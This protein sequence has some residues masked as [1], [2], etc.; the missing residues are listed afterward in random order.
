M[1]SSRSF[2]EAAASPVDIDEIEKV[3]DA[4]LLL[5]DGSAL[6][7]IQQVEAQRYLYVT[8]NVNTLKGRLGSN[9]EV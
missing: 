4:D 2:P 8:L 6:Q 1:L 5:D 7:S 3:E 9:R